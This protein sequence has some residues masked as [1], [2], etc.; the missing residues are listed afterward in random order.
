VRLRSTAP[1]ATL[2]LAAVVFALTAGCSGS[3]SDPHQSTD[4]QN[5]LEPIPAYATPSCTPDP[6]PLATTLLVGFSGGA[7]TASAPGFHLRYQY[8]AGVLAPD[9]DCLSSTRAKAAGCGSAWWGTWQWD[10]DPPG[11][12]VRGFVADAEAKGLV[13]M[14]TYYT[15][16]PASG[17]VEGAPEV[18]QAA[19]SAGFLRRYLNDFR[20]LLRQ[21]GCHRA[22]IH[23]EPDFWGYAQHEAMRVGGTAASLPAPVRTANPVDCPDQPDTIAGLGRCVVAMVRKWAPNA[24]VG[25]HASGWASGYDCIL[26][27][28]VSLDVAARARLTADF[29]AAAGAASSDFVVVDIADRDAGWR[30][31]QGQDTWIHEDSTLPSYAQAFAWSRALSDRAGKPLIWWQVPLGNMTLG[32]TSGAWKDNKVEYFFDHPDQVLQSGAVAMAFGAG[33]DGQ[34]GPETDGGYLWSRAA[35][36]G[37]AGGKPL[38]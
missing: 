30:Q 6:S 14:L 13:P 12:F 23:V 37:A 34:T 32:N 10:Q 33:A 17:V 21:V 11:A 9:A 7:S 24:K 3:T 36:L 5:G 28:D 26:N 4:S 29:L 1:L 27:R 31:S 16:L 35:A 22:F 25:L 20:F 8:I 38:P 19:A 15:I 2:P 18:T